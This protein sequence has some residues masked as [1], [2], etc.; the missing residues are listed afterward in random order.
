MGYSLL[1]GWMSSV[2]MDDGGNTYVGTEGMFKITKMRSNGQIAW[3]DTI[4]TFLPSNVFG[5]EVKA[6][7]VDSLQNVYITGRHNGTDYFGPTYTNA[8]MLT[9]KYDVNGNLLWSR[10]YVYLGNNAADIAN[11]IVV[12]KYLNVYVAGQSEPLVAGT[13]YDYFVIKYDAEGNEK[14]SIR[15]HEPGSQNNAITSILVRDSTDIF[16]SGVTITDANSSSTI[17]Q[18]Y[19]SLSWTGIPADIQK[20]SQYTVYPNPTSGAI[21]IDAPSFEKAEL[22][23]CF[24]RVVLTS[25]SRKLDLAGYAAGVYCLRIFD[26]H[27][28]PITVKVVV[29]E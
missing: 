26:H 12:D 21:T 25:V 4:P 6:I 8:D 9:V 27:K 13:P 3:I 22:I 23:D 15:Y 11:D 20:V 14:G 17:T 29:R 2:V 28:S 24:G 16:V 19:N 10:R 5:D 1:P 18:R 7:A